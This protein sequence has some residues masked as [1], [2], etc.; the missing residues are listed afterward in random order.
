MFPGFAGNAVMSIIAT[1]ILGAGLDR[2]GVLNAGLV[3][4]APLERRRGAPAAGACVAGAMSAFM[5]NPAVTALFLPVVSRISSRTGLPLSRLLLPM[6]S[7][8]CSAAR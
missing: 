7:C 1:M 3:H 5:Q 8:I 2:T 4:A 6:A